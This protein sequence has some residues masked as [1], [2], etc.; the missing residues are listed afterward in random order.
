MNPLKDLIVSIFLVTALN[1]ILNKKSKYAKHQISLG[2]YML[3]YCFLF[4]L[5]VTLVEIVGFPCML[6]WKIALKTNQSVFNPHINLIPF[7]DG[8]EISGMLNIVLFMPLG[9]LLPML[10]R[11]YRNLWSTFCYGLFLSLVIEVGQMFTMNRATDINDLIMNTIGTIC[12]W[13]VFYIMS[14]PLR[15]LENKTSV[16]ICSGDSLFIKTEPWLYIL[17]GVICSIL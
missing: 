8:L 1:I 11:K 4:Y 2:H 13:L 16:N 17:I 9:F 7:K 14:R 5:M 3:G 15:K 6:E 10:W 12:G